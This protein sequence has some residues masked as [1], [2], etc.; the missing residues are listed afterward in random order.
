MNEKKRKAFE[1]AA[2]RNLCNQIRF[3]AFA[4][5]AM[6]TALALYM[7]DIGALGFKSQIDAI[8]HDG[9]EIKVGD[10]KLNDYETLRLKMEMALVGIGGQ[11]AEEWLKTD[12]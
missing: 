4:A 3:G 11:I 10:E 2:Q 6:A 9:S 7:T 8:I 12:N 5:Y 1:A